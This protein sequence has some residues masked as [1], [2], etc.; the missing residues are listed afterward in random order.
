[1]TEKEQTGATELKTLVVSDREDR[2]DYLSV[3]AAR[4]PTAGIT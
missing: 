1:M 2:K 3:S 4:N